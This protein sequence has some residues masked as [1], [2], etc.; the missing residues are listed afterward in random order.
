METCA[1]ALCAAPCR[2]LRRTAAAL[3][4]RQSRSKDLPFGSWRLRQAAPWNHRA[5][6]T[7]APQSPGTIEPKFA[8]DRVSQANASEFKRGEGGCRT[9]RVCRANVCVRS[10]LIRR[11][12]VMGGSWRRPVRPF[13]VCCVAA[14]GLPCAAFSQRVRPTNRSS[15][16]AC[17]TLCLRARSH[18]LPNRRRLTAIVL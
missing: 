4:R 14:V 2:T 8:W 5:S 18:A 3:C 17:R 9:W 12:G 7:A 11:E 16:K 1:C 10:A 15:E 13:Q 6:I